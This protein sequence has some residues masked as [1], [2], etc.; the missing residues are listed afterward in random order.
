MATND[1]DV[2]DVDFIIICSLEQNDLNF[3]SQ[4]VDEIWRFGGQHKISEIMFFLQ[5]KMETRNFQ[6]IRVPR[7][8][9]VELLSSLNVWTSLDFE[10]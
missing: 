3:E 10:R 6:K 7:M 5:I 8:K 9:C 1:S 2:F 4:S